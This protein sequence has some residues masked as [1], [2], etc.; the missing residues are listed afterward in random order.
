MSPNR[1][2]Q[3]FINRRKLLILPKFQLLLVGINLAV[4]LL[5]SLIT[6]ISIRNALTDLRPLAGLS[7]IEVNYYKHYLDYQANSFQT[8]LLVSFVIAVIASTLITLVAS[9]RLAGPLVRM[10]NFLR[11]V[12]EL[13]KPVPPLEFRDGDYFSDIP[14]LVNR[15]VTK[16]NEKTANKGR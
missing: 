9:H 10:R 5:I 12:V 2:I 15:L 6:W 14:P 13:E 8:A 7:G 16:L 11:T 4:I 1:T 3:D